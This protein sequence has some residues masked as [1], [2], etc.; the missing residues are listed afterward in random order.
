MMR[1]ERIEK[2]F[3]HWFSEVSALLGCHTMSRTVETDGVVFVIRW[4]HDGTDYRVSHVVTNVEVARLD[5]SAL[6]EKLATVTE[7]IKRTLEET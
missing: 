4:N 3:T 6:K 7:T 5:A 1:S 2:V